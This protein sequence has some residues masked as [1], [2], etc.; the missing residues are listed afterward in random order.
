MDYS[1]RNGDVRYLSSDPTLR[2]ESH[3]AKTEVAPEGEPRKLVIVKFLRVIGSK[4]V[5]RGLSDMRGLTVPYSS[6]EMDLDV[7]V[8]KERRSRAR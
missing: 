8:R 3:V 5:C 1:L 6:C 4:L 7:H 2:Q